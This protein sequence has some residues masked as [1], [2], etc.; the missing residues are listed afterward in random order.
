MHRKSNNKGTSLTARKDKTSLTLRK[1][2]GKGH[3]GKVSG[4]VGKG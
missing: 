4:G 1:V 2:K 3:R